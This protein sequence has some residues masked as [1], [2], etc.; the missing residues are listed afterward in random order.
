MPV[1]D[2]V[3]ERNDGTAVRLEPQPNTPNVEAFEHENPA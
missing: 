1:W 2:F 3:I